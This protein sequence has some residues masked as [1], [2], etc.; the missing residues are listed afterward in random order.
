[1]S[2]ISDIPVAMIPRPFARTPHWNAR[3]GSPGDG[4]ENRRGEY[5]RAATAFTFC[6]LFT[7]ATPREAKRFYMLPNTTRD[8][9][10]T[11]A[12]L[13]CDA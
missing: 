3:E 11:F 6:F 7:F 5:L 1:M 4:T 13:D 8:V 9:I 10:D 12:S 2:I